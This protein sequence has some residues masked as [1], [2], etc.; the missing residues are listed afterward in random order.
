MSYVEMYRYG[1]NIEFYYNK[2]EWV[3]YSILKIATAF[4]LGEQSIFVLVS[5][6]YTFFWVYLICLL[7]NA[8]YRVWLIVL[9]YFT[10][11]GIYQNQLNG[12]RQYMAIAI[13]PCVFVLLYQRKYFVAT[14]LTAIATLCHAS[15]ILVYPF[16]FV[17]LFRPTPKK[18]AF[19]FIFGFATSAFFIPKLLPV[20]VNM[21]FGNYAG[22]F[23]SE[24]SAS[25][26]LLSVLTKL[27]YF[28]LFIWAFVKY[29]KS[30]REEANNKNYKMLMYF[31][32][33]LAV[34][35]W[36]FIVNMYFGFFGRVSQYFMIFYIFPIYY[37][38]DKLI[39]EK[40]TYLTIVIF[41]YLLLPYIL[42][43]TL[44]ATAEY[45]YQ[46]ILGLL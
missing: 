12:L 11:T 42:K 35:Y 33:V 26:N 18:I 40:R 28:P 21:L 38:V 36:L 37:L 30:Y 24:L 9:L 17:F 23:D 29:C 14:I 4:S 8:G 13:L 22:Y 46:T 3:F 1:Y 44:F 31:F 7:K 39:K 10:V 27:Y 20:I 16:L 34:T 32:M 6:V 45:E 43:V 41:A 2:K 5:L 19:L 15:F 25:A